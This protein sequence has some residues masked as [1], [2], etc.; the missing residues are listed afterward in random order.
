VLKDVGVGENGAKM[1]VVRNYSLAHPRIKLW[2]FKHLWAKGAVGEV[3]LSLNLP[4]NPGPIKKTPFVS[5][6]SC[7]LESA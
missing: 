5:F 1:W 7:L 4:L 2:K 3:A 6:P